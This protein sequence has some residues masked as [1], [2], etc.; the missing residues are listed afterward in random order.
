M[1]KLILVVSLFASIAFGDIISNGIAIN[2]HT[3][4][5]TSHGVYGT[6]SG[7]TIVNGNPVQLRLLVQSR[8][9]K[10]MID[11]AIVTVPDSIKL[12]ACAISPMFAEHEDNVELYAKL[13]N[14]NGF[15]SYTINGD[16]DDYDDKMPLDYVYSI[17][18]QGREGLSG[19]PM[20]YN[21]NIIGM[22]IKFRIDTA[23]T[24]TYTYDILTNYLE[25]AD[26]HQNPNTR[27]IK[28]CVYPIIGYTQAKI[29]EYKD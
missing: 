24:Y 9:E 25:Q 5:T 6:D 2:E 29:I 23:I 19:G 27:D 22:T 26:I 13:Y 17:K 8:I 12:N 21:G 7:K 1:F 11:L 20:I 28:K 16:I 14:G 18:A 3:I 4:I 15:S 10:K